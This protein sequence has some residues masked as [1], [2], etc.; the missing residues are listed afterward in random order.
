M[1][2]DNPPVFVFQ[3]DIMLHKYQS[4]IRM[5]LLDKLADIDHAEMVLDMK[6]IKIDN[7]CLM[8]EGRLAVHT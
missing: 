6:G 8:S 3:N 7:F 1:P 2:T 4:T 5:I